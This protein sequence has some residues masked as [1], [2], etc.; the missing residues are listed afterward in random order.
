MTPIEQTLVGLPMAMVLGLVFGMSACTIACLPYL[1]PV[2]LS[3][4][5]GIR[6]SWRVLLPFSLG[7]LSGYAGL[8]M[9]AGIAGHYLGAQVDDAGHVRVLVG[10][11][12]MMVGVALWL[13]RPADEA[14][15]TRGE[16]PLRHRE[17][18]PV[19]TLMPGGLFLLGIGMTLTPCAPLGVVL[20]SAAVAGS[21]W[22]G[23]VLGL[24]FG[25]GA[26]LIPSLIYGIGAAHLGA[27]LRQQLRHHRRT[28]TRV[29]GA[30]LIL[31]G[32]GNLLR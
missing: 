28:L 30:L 9:A 5:G 18:K 19:R 25:L 1:A 23:L 31:T 11:A 29:S 26:I 2:F 15:R 20:F 14:C 6:Q 17:A 13:R 16:V 21:G 4:D 7:R 27:R 12:A 32:L 22:H 8:A 24:G 10:L 3:M